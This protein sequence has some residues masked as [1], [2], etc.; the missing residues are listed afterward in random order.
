MWYTK[1]E[2]KAGNKGFRPFFVIRMRIS[3]FEI[4]IY[5]TFIYNPHKSS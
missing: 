1:K 5:G 4:G 3:E 2:S